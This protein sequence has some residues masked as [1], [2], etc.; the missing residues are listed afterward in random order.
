[1]IGRGRHKNI[2]LTGKN[3]GAAIAGTAQPRACGRNLGPDRSTSRGPFRQPF[4]K[5]P[6]S[7]RTD[8]PC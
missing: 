2:A 5:P 6:L 3:R 4:G 8:P 7:R 1:M